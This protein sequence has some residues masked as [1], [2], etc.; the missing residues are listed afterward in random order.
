M[1]ILSLVNLY[2]SFKPN[3][4]HLLKE[5]LSPGFLQAVC[6]SVLGQ[7][8]HALHRPL[9]LHSLKWLTTYLVFLL[10]LRNVCPNPDTHTH[11]RGCVCVCVQLLSTGTPNQGINERWF[12]HTQ[13]MKGC[14]PFPG[15]GNKVAY[16]VRDTSISLRQSP[17]SQAT[18]SP[19]ALCRPTQ[20]FS[21]LFVSLI[22]YRDAINWEIPDKRS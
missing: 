15:L 2:L 9:L 18:S 4:Y 14:L 20:A 8:H 17:F 21:H 16:K 10:K 22:S 6:S 1:P 12:L 5:T 7:A 11:T 19:R 3:K 13:K